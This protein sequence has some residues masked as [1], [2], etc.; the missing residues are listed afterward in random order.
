ME[1]WFT[2]YDQPDTGLLVEHL[3]PSIL[4]ANHSL[5][6]ETQDRTLFFGELGTALEALHGRLMIISSPPHEE[7][8]SSQ[9]PWLWRYMS[10]FMVGAE[11]RA[12]QH[13]KLWAFHWKVGNEDYLE[14]HISSTNLT[15]SAFKGQVQAGWRYCKR[16]QKKPTKT[17]QQTW[18][19]LIQFL[20]G[21]GASAGDNAKKHID[22]LIQLLGKA[23]CPEDVAFVAS[24]PG[25]NKRAAQM[26]K[27]LRPSAIHILTPTI[28]DWSK[29]TLTAW[30]KDVGISPDKIHL[31]WLAADHPWANG[32]GWTLTEQAGK[33]LQGKGVQLNHLPSDARFSNMHENGDERWSHAKL[34]LLRIP[35]KKKRRLLVSSA[36]WSP[37]AWGAGSKEPPRN[38]ELGVV[39]NTDWKMLEYISGKLSA[40]FCTERSRTGNSKLQWAD[41]TWDGKR[42]NLRAR[43]SDSSMPITATVSFTGGS[44]HDLAI[45]DCTAAMPWNDPWRTPL[46]ARFKQGTEKLEVDFLDLRPPAEFAKT[47]L[48]EVDPALAAALREA[49]LLQR[50]GGPVVDL[51]SISGFDGARRPPGVG[52]PAADYSVQ[53]WLD[54]RAAFDVVDQW[55]DALTEAKTKEKT[56]PEHLERVCLDGKDLRAFFARREGP[57]AGLVVEELGWR[58]EEEA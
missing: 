33:V 37:S 20:E 42:I 50:Y 23:E 10:H 53:A 11:S 13:A 55:R 22:R 31:K 5:S 34:Y 51:E 25:S 9:Y 27:K 40:A 56:E 28:G 48:P 44:E 32:G 38:F 47:P 24:T 57:A 15:T 26:L 36:N 2:T 43:S 49:F 30:S 18:G 17:R 4:G 29:D 16:H 46:I 14:L 1:A 45:V 8:K 21:L 35:N 19:E 41:A 58:I 6:Q 12:V 7:R 52:A 3:L 39:L 54:A